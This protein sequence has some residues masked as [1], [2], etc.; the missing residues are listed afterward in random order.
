MA[1]TPLDYIDLRRLYS[2][3]P[4]EYMGLNYAE[5]LFAAKKVEKAIKETNKSYYLTETGRQYFR[6]LRRDKLQAT[7]GTAPGNLL[8][9]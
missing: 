6:R 8:Q 9:S 2:I 5:W 3:R 1:N 4:A 7:R